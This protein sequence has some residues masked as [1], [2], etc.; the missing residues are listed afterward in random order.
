MR[1][2]A[3]LVLVSLGL[4]LVSCGRGPEKS[5]QEPRD[6]S[7]PVKATWYNVPP[8][9]LAKR[10]AGEA[11]LT[12]A[13]DHYKLGTLLRVH[14]VSNGRQVTVRVTDTGLQ[15]SKSRIDLCKEAAEQ[16]EMVS[17]G[18]ASVRLTVLSSEESRVATV[19]PR[20]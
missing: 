4:A 19:A 16:L 3:S 8:D 18:V 13:T 11:E 14:R 12:A 7:R 9:S 15:A 1:F 10:R 17:D 6:E 20:P 5:A 2:L